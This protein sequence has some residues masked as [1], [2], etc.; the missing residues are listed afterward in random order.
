MKRELSLDSV[1]LNDP[2]NLKAIKVEPSETASKPIEKMCVN[3]QKQNLTTNTCIFNSKGNSSISIQESNKKSVCDNKTDYQLS[4]EKV[5]C[6]VNDLSDIEEDIVKVQKDSIKREL[7]L[8]NVTLNDPSNLKAIKVEP[9]EINNN[10]IQ[11]QCVNMKENLPEE[12][13][14]IE[15]LNSCQSDSSDIEDDINVKVQ[16]NSIRC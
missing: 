4:G 11:Y 12:T 16:N 9:S 8:D 2:S 15:K 10:T 1:T 3:V 6:C 13:T 7:S 5:H 14:Y